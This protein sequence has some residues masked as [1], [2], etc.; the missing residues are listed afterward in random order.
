MGIAA[1]LKTSAVVAVALHGAMFGAVAGAIGHRGRATPEPAAVEIEV[2]AA[3]P[4]P[5]AEAASATPEATPAPVAQRRLRVARAHVAL[6]P[7]ADSAPEAPPVIAEAAAAPA[8]DDVARPATPAIAPR[9]SGASGSAPA[10]ASSGTLVSATPRYRSNPPPDYPLPS[11]RR[12]EEGIVLLTVV[13][14]AS[15]SPSAI[16]LSRTSGHPLLD[17]A[18]L[19]AVRHWTFEPARAAN[20]PVTS[21]VVVPVRFSLSDAP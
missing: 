20:V 15:G 16:S 17:R 3:R 21:S 18:A 9:T 2:V 4:D 12:R 13:V 19:E 6:A 14:Q 10:A 1:R 7:S 11:R 5:I 8:A